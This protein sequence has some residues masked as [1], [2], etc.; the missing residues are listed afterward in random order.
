M[1]L[2]EAIPT[3]VAV[4]PDSIPIAPGRVD[5]AEQALTEGD[6]AELGRLV[7]ASHRSLGRFGAS[8]PALDGLTAAMR[9]AGATGSRL[10]GAGFGGYAIAVCRPDQVAAV[11][12]AGRR[13]TGGPAFQVLPSMG[14]R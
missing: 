10:T 12:A 13:A 5:L 3:A 4:G 2:G 14:L 9:S 1:T 7:D 11:S 6:L 8:T